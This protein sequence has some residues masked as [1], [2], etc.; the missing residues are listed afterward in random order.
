MEA[1]L[2]FA[3]VFVLGFLVLINV[4]SILIAIFMG[5]KREAKNKRY[6]TFANY[7]FR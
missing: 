1:F 4:L 2:L 7:H 5:S 6:R 3:F